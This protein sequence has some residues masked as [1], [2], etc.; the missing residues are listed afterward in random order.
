[1]ALPLSALARFFDLLA[2]VGVVGALS[3]RLWVLPARDEPA[4]PDRCQRGWPRI[5]V[6][7]FAAIAGLTIT[8]PLLLLMRAGE[9][10]RQTLAGA[11]PL[12]PKVLAGS[13]YGS[14][15][16]VRAAALVV[17]WVWVFWRGIGKGPAAVMWVAMLAIGW[18][19]SA[20]GHASAWGDFSLA[21]LIDGMHVASTA[22]WVGGVL[23]LATAARPLFLTGQDRA[24]ALEAAERLSR[25]AGLALL[26][27]VLTGTYNAVTQIGFVSAL[28]ETAYGRLLLLK[29]AG[30]LG[31]AGLG[32][33]NRY[34]GL[35]GL[36]DWAACPPGPRT[37]RSAGERFLRI[38]T[39]ESFLV[40]WVLGC[41][42]VLGGAMPPREASRTEGHHAVTVT[43]SRS[44][45]G[46][47]KAREAETEG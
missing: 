40:V 29:L 38:A 6:M 7:L 14:V 9:M 47:D 39:L 33:W 20:S 11:V 31:V 42:A 35:R 27:V 23:V 8:T 41:T 13:H 5:R 46:A 44:L 30:V 4:R 26:G 15:W 1:M 10:G 2:F 18:T 28:W 16:K 34:R 22:I 17:L 43:S 37:V 21:Q 12:V 32:A 3:W 45:E 19:Y 36:R 24:Y 25:L